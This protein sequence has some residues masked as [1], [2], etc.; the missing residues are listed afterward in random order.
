MVAG[1]IALLNVA[2]TVALLGQVATL[3]SG[4]VTSVTVGAAAAHE[5][6]VVN[7]HTK[8]ASRVLPYV[9]ATP[10]EIVAVNL[11]FGV[12]LAAG[13]KVATLVADA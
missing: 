5:G 2:L 7:V 9:S 6:E 13:V 8:L 12:R 10:V 3:P 1:F 4:G 11:V